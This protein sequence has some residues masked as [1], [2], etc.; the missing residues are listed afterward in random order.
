MSSLLLKGIV[1]DCST[2]QFCFLIFCSSKTWL[3]RITEERNIPE[4]IFLNSFS[5]SPFTDYLCQVSQLTGR[6]LEVKH[7]H[8]N[9][10]AH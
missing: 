8:H 6:T 1:G 5:F 7:S 9:T 2:R 4:I 10:A 3:E